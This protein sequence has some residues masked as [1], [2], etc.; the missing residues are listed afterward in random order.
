MSRCVQFVGFFLGPLIGVAMVCG[1]AWF[2]RSRP[3]IVDFSVSGQ[4]IVDRRVIVSG[5]MNR[6][7]GC[8]LIEIVAHTSRAGRVGIQLLD[9]QAQARL[10][11]QSWGPWA[12]WA[13]PGDG[14]T[15]YARHQCVPW[16]DMTTKLGSFVVGH[17]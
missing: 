13:A 16:W 17:P 6:A 3:V 10:G 4:S 1:Y 8:R 15:L 9:V 2:D 5:T 7:R 12:V 11:P 14:V